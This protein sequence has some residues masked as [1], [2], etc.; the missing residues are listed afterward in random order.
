MSREPVSGL[1]D[2]SLPAVSQENSLAKKHINSIEFAGDGRELV[3][4]IAVSEMV[5]LHD[6]VRNDAGQ[7][8]GQMSVALNG[9]LDAGRKHWL[10]LAIQGDL[11]VTCQRCLQ[12]LILPLS[13]ESHL[14]LIRPGEAW[15]EDEVD[16]GSDEEPDDAIEADEALDLLAL[17][18]EEV[19][20]ALPYAPT[21]EVCELPAADGLNKKASPFAALEVLKKH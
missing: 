21:H 8:S 6:V 15:P 11:A 14:R 19:I 10:H 18:E 12:P 17:I 16:E 3:G 13:I 20:L 7:V 1:S 9:E 4:Q 5:R 2:L